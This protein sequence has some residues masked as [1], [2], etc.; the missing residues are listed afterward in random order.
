MDVFMESSFKK[1]DHLVMVC[2]LNCFYWCLSR[3]GQEL[4]E[5][6]RM[7]IGFHLFN[8][9]DDWKLLFFHPQHTGIEGWLQFRWSLRKG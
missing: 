1:H 5:S 3:F 4:F 7:T 9:P 6:Y 2:K 8:T